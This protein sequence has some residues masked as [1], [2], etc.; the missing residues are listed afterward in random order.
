MFRHQVRDLVAKAATHR[1][2]IE[3][4]RRPGNFTGH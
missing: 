1:L 3:I 4:E 2:A